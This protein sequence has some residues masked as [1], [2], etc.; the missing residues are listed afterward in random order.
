M[1]LRRSRIWIGIL[2]VTMLVV[3]AVGSF[4]IYVASEAGQLPWQ[5]DPTRIAVTP[6]ANLPDIGTPE[7]NG[8]A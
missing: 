2:M 4:G 3:I 8:G 7:A 6:F 1:R 5:A